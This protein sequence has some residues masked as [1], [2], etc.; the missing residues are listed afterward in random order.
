MRE[1]PI[2]MSGPLVRE[3]LAGRKDVTR[4]PVKGFSDPDAAELLRFEGGVATFGHRIPDDPVPIS[5]RCPYGVAGD[6]LWIRETFNLDGMTPPGAPPPVTY[7]ADWD[8][9]D[10]IPTK[11]K[12]GIHMP[13][14]ACRLELDVLDV[15]V[16]RLQDVT[17]QEARREGV[18]DVIAFALKWVEIYG[19]GDHD[20]NVNPWVWRIGFRR[21][22]AGRSAA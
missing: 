11:W 13:R 8:D 19:N 5:I 9:G 14:W 16:E 20:W 18:E 7:R 10:A 22:E 2:L 3:I 12:P 15:R 6:R 4:R 17:E 1:R 21:V